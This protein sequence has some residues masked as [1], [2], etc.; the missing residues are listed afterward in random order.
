MLGRFI[1]TFS[2]IL[3]ASGAHAAV[4]TNISGNVMLNR[5]DGFWEVTA[6]TVVN[7]GDRVLVRGEGGGAIDYGNGCVMPVPANA[8]VIV[9]SAPNCET[10]TLDSTSSISG[11][12]LKDSPSMA[13]VEEG[14]D[15]QVLIVGG[16]VAVGGAAAITAFSDGGD[17]KP[18]SP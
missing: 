4:L 6:P 16:I 15:Q 17:G 10:G 9:A 2:G 11:V 3:I 1:A 13:P 12:S 8:S 18:A 5:G 7:P 14:Y